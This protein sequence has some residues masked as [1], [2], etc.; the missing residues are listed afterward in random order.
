MIRRLC[1]LCILPLLISSLMLAQHGGSGYTIVRADYGAGSRWRDVTSRVNSL[2]QGDSLSF[3]VTN[4]ALGGDPAPEEHKTLRLQVRAVGGQLKTLSYREKDTVN[5]PIAI[6]AGGWDGRWGSGLQITRAQYGAGTRMW[7]VTD[8]VRSQM[9]NNQLSLRV[10]N[11]TMGGDPAEGSRKM[12]TVWYTD[13]GRS[14]QATINEGDYL[15]LGMGSAAPPL[16]TQ[17]GG[18]RILRAEYGVG[19]RLLDVT[20]RLSAQVQGDQLSL[21]ITNETMG[22]D[23]AEEH[24][25]QLTVWYWYN[26]RTARV[27]VPEKSTLALPASSF[28]A[29]GNLHV[30]R[31]Q[32]G[33][34]YR[35][36]DVTRLLNSSMQGDQL[37]LRITNEN[38]GGD[39]APERP[40]IL[41]VF[42][43]YNGQPARVTVNEK[44]TLNLPGAG[45]TGWTSTPGQLQILRAVYGIGDLGMDVT[46]RVA[47]QIRGDTLNFPVNG[48][49]MGGDPAP[50][51]VKRL[52]VI[53]LWQGL[54]YETN[55]PEKGVLSLP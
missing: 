27:V 23:P 46:G 15:N 13:H 34:D 42:Y 5:L 4:E 21:R 32:Y 30:M 45:G 49:S 24:A 35:F 2:V 3:R 9:R 18:L 12:L 43:V 50:G 40:K 16:A 55:V 11:D 39:P 26:G 41:T 51:Q 36:L 33:A 47:A 28:D 17:L 25:K 54:R 31:A 37:T 22:G 8:R 29:I 7:D 10:S 14:A 6:A 1:F 53:Y 44:D 20:N 48:E 19:E 38:M 52:K